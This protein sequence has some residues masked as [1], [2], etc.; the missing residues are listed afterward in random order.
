[1]RKKIILLSGVI[2]NFQLNKFEESYNFR[3]CVL[4]VI[5]GDDKDFCLSKVFKGKSRRFLKKYNV[6]EISLIF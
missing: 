3:M 4:N 5:G 2:C 1:M 6:D